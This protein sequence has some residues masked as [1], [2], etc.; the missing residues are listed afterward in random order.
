MHARVESK[1]Q[2][3]KTNKRTYGVNCGTTAPPHRVERQRSQIPPPPTGLWC[4]RGEWEAL[5]S[6][7]FWFA[8]SLEL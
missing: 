7:A 4:R 1:V 6:A 8:G 3:V 2:K 5:I